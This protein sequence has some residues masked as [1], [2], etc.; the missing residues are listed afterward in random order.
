MNLCG[1]TCELTAATGGAGPR[2]AVDY[3][4]CFVFVSLIVA[5]RLLL[6][7]E[8]PV[9]VPA[10]ATSATVGFVGVTPVVTGA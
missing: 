5:I 7:E 3:D 2:A 4:V 1:E 9:D 8:K 10:D 6:L